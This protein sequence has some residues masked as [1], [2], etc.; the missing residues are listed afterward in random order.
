MFSGYESDQT[1]IIHDEY[2]IYR[3]MKTRIKRF[4]RIIR[5]LF[6]KRNDY[7]SL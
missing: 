6:A 3:R 5:S 2:S 4:L 7:Q 1:I